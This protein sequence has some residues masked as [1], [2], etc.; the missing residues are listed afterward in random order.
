MRT[1][2][3]REAELLQIAAGPARVFDVSNEWI[4][5]QEDYRFLVHRGYVAVF[6]KM[7]AGALII[8]FQPTPLGRLALL[9]WQVAKSASLEGAF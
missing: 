2:T 7:V 6:E 5:M 4:A 1:L 3:A 8:N 9:C